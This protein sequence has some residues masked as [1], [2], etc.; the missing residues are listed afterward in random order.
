MGADFAGLWVNDNSQDKICSNSRTVFLVTFLILLYCG[1]QI[2]RE[3]FILIFFILVF[4]CCLVLLATHFHLN[5][6]IK[7]VNENLVIYSE[8]LKF[9][10]AL[11]FIITIMVP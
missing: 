7:E 1:Y 9:F 4:W 3:M 2:Y 10:K 6:F 5:G 8:K 11:L